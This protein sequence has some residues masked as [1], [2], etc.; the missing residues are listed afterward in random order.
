MHR[1]FVQPSAQ[2][3]DLILDGTRPIE[4]LAQEL[5][6]QLRARRA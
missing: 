4:D 1:R 3:A 5:A 2:H 6:T